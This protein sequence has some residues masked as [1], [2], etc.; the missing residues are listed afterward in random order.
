MLFLGAQCDVGVEGEDPG[1]AAFHAAAPGASQRELGE[2]S[3][4]TSTRYLG[5]TPRPA[6]GSI[7]ISEGWL[8][9]PHYWRCVYV[10]V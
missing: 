3:Y 7:D 8:T 2:L 6:K 1:L 10:F 9:M 4:A 5:S